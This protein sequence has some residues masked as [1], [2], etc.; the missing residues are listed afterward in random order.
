MN[1]L[2]CT[3]ETFGEIFGAQGSIFLFSLLI[4]CIAITGLNF[5]NSCGVSQL[6]MKSDFIYKNYA[7][8]EIPTVQKLVDLVASRQVFPIPPPSKIFGESLQMSSS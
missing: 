1:N 4:V 2:V 7:I 6:F 8:A 3:D 5:K